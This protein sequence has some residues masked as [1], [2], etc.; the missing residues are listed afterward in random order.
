[1]LRRF[2]A[3]GVSAN[4]ACSSGNGQTAKKLTCAHSRACNR[5]AL[6]RPGG[7]AMF[8]P[9]PVRLAPVPAIIFMNRLRFWRERLPRSV[10]F[11][12]LAAALAGCRP[13]PNQSEGVELV[14]SSEEPSPG[15][16]FELRFASPMAQD[17]RP[18]A[19]AANSPLVITPPLRGRFTWLSPRGGVFTPSEPLALATRYELSLRPELRRADGQPTRAKLRWSVVTPPFGLAAAWPRQAETNAASEPEIKLVFNADTT[20]REAAGFLSFRDAG[21]DRLPADV[22]QGTMEEVP[23]EIAGAGSMG[24]WA[25]GF[26]VPGPSNRFLASTEPER[27]PTNEVGNLLIATPRLPLPVGRGWILILG[28]GLPARDSSLRLREPAD[29]PVGDITPFILG[30]ATAENLISSGASIRLWFSKPVSESVTNRLADWLAISPKP[31]N[32]EARVLDRVLTLRG[33]FKG[34]TS[35]TLTLRAA[36]PAREPFTLAI[37]SNVT[38]RMPPVAPRLYFPALSQDQLAGGARA[39]PLLAVN[40]AAARVRAKV[41]DAQS[42][43]HALRG[44]GSYFRS[45][46]ERRDDGDWSEEYQSL[47]YN[48]LPGR[49]VFDEILELD[50]GPD[51]AKRLDL[52]WDRMLHGRKTAVVFLD[53]RRAGDDDAG[54]SAL[55][56]QALI[57]LTDLALVWK[58]DK[59]GV[60]V[61]VFSHTTGQPVAG[62]TA[63]LY[64]DENETLEEAVT[65]DNGIARLGARGK[66]VWV[67]ALKGDDFRALPLHENGVWLS[68]FNLPFQGSDQPDEP[69]RVMLFSDRNL[70]RPGEEVHLAALARDWGERGLSVPSRLTGALECLDPR[71]RRFFQTNA[72]FS[73]SGG[74]SVSIPLPRAARG[75]YSAQLRVG[76][77]DYSHSFQV[78][79]FQPGA[80][81]ISLPCKTAFAADEKIT[82]PLS[83][84][85]LFG[86]PLSRARVK[87]SLEAEDMEFNPKGFE[88]FTFRRTELESRF[89]RGN[90]SMTLHGEGVLTGPTNFIIAPELAVN[91]AAPQP[92][93]ASLLVEVTDLN[94]QTLSRRVEFV[95]HSSAFYLGLKQG[96]RVLTTNN[97]LVLEVAAV[98]ADGQP[99]PERAKA[100]LTLQRISWQTVHLQ[101]AG[102]TVRYRSEAV[103]TNVFEESIEVQPVQIPAAPGDGT[104]GNQL[105][106][107]PDLAAGEYLADIQTEDPAGRLVRS[108]LAFSVSAPAE[109]SWNYRNDVQLALKPGRERYAPGETAEILVEAPFSATAYVTIERNK[110][111]RSFI[112]R[113]EGNAPSIR[114]PLEPGDAPNV[115]VSVV[116]VR[117][118]DNCPRKIKEPEYRLGYCELPVADPQGRLAVIVA[119]GATNYLPGQTVEVAVRVADAGGRVAPGAEVVLYAVDDGILSLTD[120]ELPDPYGFFYGPRPL[121][122]QTC[123]SLP[124]LLSEDPQ[125]LR[126]QNKGY[127]GGGGGR[128]RVRKNFLACAYWNAALT[129]DSQGRARARFPAPDSLTRYRIFAVAHAAD[130]FGS[131][132]S[133]FQISKPLVIE[134]ALPAFANIT[135]RLQA[136]GLIQNQTSQNGEVV[137]TLKLDEKAKAGPPDQPLAKRVSISAGGSAVVEFPVEFIGAGE[138][139][140]VWEARFTD[141][142]A[143]RFADAVQSQ[144]QVG[145]L[146]PLLREILLNRITNS[147][148][149]LLAAANPR[150]L[151][152]RGAITVSLANT[153]LVEL[154]EAV[155]QLL[156]YPYGCVEQ[157]GSSLLPWILLRDETS[158]AP[159]LLRGTND[160]DAVIAAG[161]ARFF[162]MQTP[163]GGLGYWPHAKEPMLW[164]SAY[165]G[166]VL[167]LARRHGVEVPKDEFA[168]LLDYL[169]R[170]LRSI[171]AEAA[172]LSDDCLALYAL[173]LAGRAEPA[174][175]ERL[176]SLRE[177]L[178]S[179]ERALLELAIA[180]SHGST[181]MIAQLLQ[182]G[183]ASRRNEQDP[184][185]CDAREQAVHLLAWS[186]YRPENPIV[187]TLA[188]GLM[189]EQKQG[190]WETTQGDAWSL[191]ALTEYARRVEG[192]LQP[193]KGELTWAGQ[194]IPFWLEGRTNLFT[195][196]FSFTNLADAALPL[197]NAS[198]HRIF[199]SVSIEAWPPETPQPRQD[200]GFGLRRRYERLDDDNHPQDLRGLRVGDR[201]LVTLGLNVRESARYVVIDDAL[202]SILEAVNP[203]LNTK[204]V[205]LAGYPADDGVGWPGDFQE[206]R[207]E[208]CL[209]FADWIAPGDHTW[210]YVARVRAAGVVTAPSAKVE[211][212]YHPDRYGLSE[213]QT[214]S[215]EDVP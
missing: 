69:R 96:A 14:M 20:A 171:G 11:I 87:W 107:F 6:A 22:R 21:G 148:G 113:L 202:P 137:V 12:F 23:D 125:N 31:T 141:P 115:F 35:Y 181:G 109:M 105:A 119:P 152:G 117:G 38:L 138:S 37:S 190:H 77:N 26:A 140:W 46:R 68:G 40:V 30:G 213:S 2:Y 207:K 86:K 63:R 215:S 50:A 144:I 59:E 205:R 132:Q 80:F 134:P 110:V 209:S 168:L 78:Q 54:K 36:F 204:E 27:G 81:E 43:I 57:Q 73:P 100:R 64:G 185:G 169:R 164:G 70:Y 206:L 45:W 3:H 212:M 150:L 66:A 163:S 189:R 143:G 92:R 61:F 56:T 191:L 156:H 103:L 174:Y 153:R 18:A 180:E 133:V 95:R 175:H 179:E 13:P 157:T 142:A 7:C 83:A 74:W 124:N 89:Q 198:N 149:N 34:E 82:A 42:A 5:F 55:G 104:R 146:A 84:R 208:R 166:M 47:N 184:F 199:T 120:Y 186:R 195:R 112:T 91:P 129:T 53:A 160:V 214:L 147:S 29:V 127:L 4:R 16:T 17:G 122:V 126:F 60:S 135:D 158:L 118:A 192:A 15:M 32:L 88:G 97:P 196:S 197:F 101:G 116:L 51:S 94:Q 203:G 90:S 24:S 161:V 130:H 102:K 106:G 201:V 200:H 71:G 136:R 172:P 128:N 19:P 33:A 177:K 79:D 98:R 159:L 114:V 111:L 155:A 52:G 178:S 25:R 41:M 72:A 176:F 1:M 44:Y 10:V 58:K 211:E 165:G 99:W 93:S 194:T 173:A 131:G 145:H 9:R 170:E 67:A 167:A 48:L 182:P 154:G 108:S 123:V 162:T 85:Y 49:T 8:L 187:D 62:V 39:F 76:S 188:D 210:R 75:E 183:P 139:K 193:A 28:P 121:G 151:A 65:D